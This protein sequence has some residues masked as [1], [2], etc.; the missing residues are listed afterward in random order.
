MRRKADGVSGPHPSAGVE[1]KSSADKAEVSALDETAASSETR[2]S[3]PPCE[4]S[5]SVVDSLR[6]GLPRSEP[7]WEVVTLQWSSRTEQTKTLAS[8]GLPMSF[9]EPPPVVVA[10]L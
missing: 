3:A 5:A 9:I 2:N 1:A 7:R 6:P 4:R 10:A 8:R